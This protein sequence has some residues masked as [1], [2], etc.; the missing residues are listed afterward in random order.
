MNQSVSQSILAAQLH[1]DVFV[2][3]EFYNSSKVE[4]H[5]VEEY[6][7]L[8]HLATLAVTA[9]KYPLKWNFTQITGLLEEGQFHLNKDV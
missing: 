2:L 4:K 7:K 9:G 1:R 3:Q 5:E 6:T 8:V